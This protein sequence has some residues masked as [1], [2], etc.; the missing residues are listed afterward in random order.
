[1]P[2]T[3]LSQTHKTTNLCHPT[4]SLLVVGEALRVRALSRLSKHDHWSNLAHVPCYQ[5]NPLV[6]DHG[7][8][9]HGILD[10]FET[11]HDPCFGIHFGIPCRHRMAFA[12][13]LHAFEV[14][15]H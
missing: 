5:N 9:Y 15:V 11:H 13:H 4:T 3:A 6:H 2:A 1:M 7:L 10:C 8:H 12:E 14:D